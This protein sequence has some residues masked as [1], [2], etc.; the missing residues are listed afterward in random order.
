MALQDT[1]AELAAY[2]PADEEH[3]DVARLQVLTDRLETVEQVRA[4]IPALL[5][6]F[7]RFPHALLGSPGPVVHCIERAGLETFLPMLLQSFMT[8]PTRMTLWMVERCLRSSLSPQSRHSILHTLR[9][10][11]MAPEG[12][13]LGSDIGELIDEYG[14]TDRLPP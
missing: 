9:Q 2:V 11:R 8:R 6:I 3:E 7:E 5:R 12:I 13:E 10:V 1:L 4:A 14:P